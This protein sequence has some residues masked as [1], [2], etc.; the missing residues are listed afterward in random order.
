[1]HSLV[2]P[3]LEVDEIIRETDGS[4]QILTTIAKIVLCFS[5][6]FA[7]EVSVTESE[8]VIA[9]SDRGC[10]ICIFSLPELRMAILDRGN[11]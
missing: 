3:K 10:C 9:V 11:S 1:M 8:V 7:T 2:G 4:D 6:L 5:Q